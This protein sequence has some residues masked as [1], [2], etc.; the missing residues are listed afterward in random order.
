MGLLKQTRNVVK[1][2]KS[3][4]ENS[5]GGVALMLGLTFPIVFIAAGGAVDYTNAVATKQKAQRAMDSTVLALTRRDLGGVNVQAEGDAL[6]RSLL[7]NQK[8]D[9]PTDVS[10]TLN[11][12]VISASSVVATKTFFLNFIG[13]DSVDTR[14]VS[15]AVPAIAQPIEIALVLDVSGSMGNDLNGQRRIDRM[16]TGV[17]ALF[18]T[19]DDVLPG[20]ADLSAALVPYSTSVNLGDYPQALQAV[21]VGDEPLPPA[22][23]DVWA[24]ERTSFQNG[25]EFVID[26]SSPVGRP[27]PFVT[28][29]ELTRAPTIP[30]LRALSRD[31][32][33]LKTAVGSLEPRGRTAGHIGMAW[34]VYA[35]SEKWA[36]TWPQDPR[37]LNEASKIIVMLTDGR[38]NQTYNIGDRNDDDTLHSDA[39]FR[40]VCQLAQSRGITVYTIALN[41]N[42]GDTSRLSDCV[43]PNGLFFDVDTANGLTKAFETIGRRLGT[44]RLT[45]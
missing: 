32:G 16:K 25:T 33:G 22:G 5:D 1:K 21:S 17:N 18:N 9:A 43:G 14:I 40:E 2:L 19:L 31:I 23:D 6:F 39:Y 13:I 37:P 10:F 38:F 44:N 45:S 12:K 7:A 8:I 11:N 4:R 15:S 35:L 3:F 20:D 30:R 36:T 42:G 24:A 41:L 27:I 29:G 34:G 26:D 28:E